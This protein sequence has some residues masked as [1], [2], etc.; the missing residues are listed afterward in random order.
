LT[1]AILPAFVRKGV[2]ACLLVAVLFSAGAVWAESDYRTPRAG[3]EYTTTLFGEQVT[4]PARD[5]TSETALNLGVVW[6]ADAPK[7]NE[8]LPF[9]AFFLWRNNDEGRERFRG[10][11]AGF[12]DDIRYNKRPSWLGSTELV[13]TFENL[14]IPVDRYE[15]VEG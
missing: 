5:R 2:L 8:F 6:V 14:T 12:Y 11:M 3:E 15:F 13:F 7:D 1:N 9:G 10:V 4:A